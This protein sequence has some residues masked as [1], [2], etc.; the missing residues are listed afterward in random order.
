MFFDS[1]Y[2]NLNLQK[3]L[4]NAVLKATLY[5]NKQNNLYTNTVRATPVYADIIFNLCKMFE[6]SIDHDIKEGFTKSIVDSKERTKEY[7]KD[8]AMGIHHGM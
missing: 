7:R 2:K 4:A 3:R 8:T 6:Q 5:D 1:L